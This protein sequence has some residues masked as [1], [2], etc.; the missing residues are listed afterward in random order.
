MSFRFFAFSWKLKDRY[1]SHSF[2]FGSFQ[3]LTTADNRPVSGFE[4]SE[5]FNG[6]GCFNRVHETDKHWRLTYTSDLKNLGGTS[7]KVD[8]TTGK[9]EIKWGYGTLGVGGA[10]PSFGRRDLIK[11]R[12]L[13]V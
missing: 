9:M 6:R 1:A 13:E 11:L 5:R 7:P 3:E 4:A 10:I 8:E 2:P 12:R